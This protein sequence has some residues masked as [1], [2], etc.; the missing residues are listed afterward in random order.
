M[1]HR[2]QEILIDGKHGGQ[3]QGHIPARVGGTPLSLPLG[4]HTLKSSPGSHGDYDVLDLHFPM[5]F[6]CRSG[7]YF[8][9]LSTSHASK[10]FLTKR[11][12][13]DINSITFDYDMLS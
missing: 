10:K 5:L 8:L 9:I 1:C 3:L 7:S 6:L 11:N 4:W 12:V 2:N 13:T